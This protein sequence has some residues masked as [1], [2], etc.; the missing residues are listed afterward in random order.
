MYTGYHT[1]WDHYPK[2][3]HYKEFINPIS[4][5]SEFFS[6]HSLKGHKRDL[7][8]WR[9]YAVSNECF[10]EERFGPGQLLYT[11]ELNVKLLEAMYI[12]FINYEC[13]YPKPLVPT[14]SQLQEEKETWRPFPKNLSAKELLNPYK[15]IKRIFK[16]LSLPQ[17]REH[18]Y[19]WLS[20]GLTIKYNAEGLEAA[21]VIMVYEN[22][23][24]LYAAAW[25]ILQ[26]NDMPAHRKQLSSDAATACPNKP[27]IENNNTL[28]EIAI[29]PLGPKLTPA[30]KLGL[31]EVVKVILKEVP[32][33]QMINF[34]GIHPKP[35]TY[36]L[37]IVI[38]NNTQAADNEIS[39]LIEEKCRALVSVITFV[40]KA[41]NVKAGMH[42]GRRFWNLVIAKSINVYQSPELSLPS[43]QTLSK[44][45]L[46]SRAYSNWQTWG[47][48]GQGFMK[49]AE[50]Y[51]EDGN[52]RLAVFLLHQAA[53][54]TLRGVT[55][56]MLGYS[57]AI[58][59][60]S[61]VLRITLLFTDDLMNVFEPETEE[62]K[63]LLNLLQSAYV[64]AK[65]KQGFEPD[66]QS[67]M[68]LTEKVGLMLTNSAALVK[69][70]IGNL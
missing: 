5:L 6:A 68:W 65:Y 10:Q 24:K 46:M 49:G 41:G 48:Q 9:H 26:R 67:V 12:I 2:Y 20:E 21:D 13:T 17:Y 42:N 64:E 63:R 29:R 35:F 36:Y 70:F 28:P 33:V 8:E 57:P 25:V 7:T 3:L 51:L 59:T 27:V 32:S 39:K 4:F 52:F 22:L 15:V 56:V 18:L 34:L 30:E 14:E 37:V 47:I 62:G 43:P 16:D 66:E 45:I 38:D 19:E 40:H 53:E 11:H 55:K 31:D 61:R 54:S 1:P 23:L 50:Q 69:Q 58:H 60:L 44:D